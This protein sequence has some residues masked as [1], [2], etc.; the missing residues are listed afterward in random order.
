L[1]AELKRARKLKTAEEAKNKNSTGVD[2][3]TL[4]EKEE[5]NQDDDDGKEKSG[6]KEPKEKTD[7]EKE[8]GD[9][10]PICLEILPKDDTHFNRFTCCGNGIHIH[11][12]KDMMSM[13]M[14]GTCP[15]CRAKTPSCA[16][17]HIKYLRPW[18]KKKTAWAQNMMGQM[19]VQGTGV[20]QSYELAKVLYELAAQQGNVLAMGNLGV[21]YYK[22]LGVEQSY[23]RA[24]EYYAHAAHLGFAGAQKSLGVM[25]YTGNGVK[26]DLKKAREWWNKAAS[27]GHEDAIKNLK[28]LN[29][30]EGRTTTASTSSSSSE[31]NTSNKSSIVYCSTCQTPQT[32]TFILK[33]C[34]CRAAQ[35]C[36][37]TC[38][39]KHR[40]KHAKE[41]RR[42]TA[43]RKSKKK[44]S[45]K[46]LTTQ[47]EGERKEDEKTKPKQEKEEE[48][49]EEEGDECPICLENLPKDTTKFNRWTCCGNGIHKHCFKD[50]KSMKMA[51]TCPLCRAKTPTSDEEHIKQ[52]RPWVKKKKAWALHMMGSMYRKGEGVKQSYEMAKR[53]FEQAAQQGDVTALYDLGF[54]YENGQGV[55]KS[56]EKAF[57]YYEQAADLGHVSAQFNLGGLYYHGKG[58]ERDIA[59]A[60]E[61]WTASAA[62]GFEKAIENLKI[63]EKEMK[64]N[65][66]KNATKN[67]K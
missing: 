57:E 6:T 56:N 43:E 61:W 48:E 46:L 41:C 33:K 16:E 36:D 9:E 39:Q 7:K 63:L 45:K 4:P 15:F 22:G 23:E 62:Q 24:V 53:L 25:Y 59:K 66:T 11:C 10:C 60:K 67:T 35:Y 55:E 12:G 47:E 37:K 42:L 64:K 49:E 8:E 30:E 19:Y 20:K 29:K 32:E 58:V 51:G 2:A 28:I 31:T 3:G 17:D 14:A 44:Q 40:M 18:V 54:M 27:Q 13:K 50:M 65:M 52:L 26:R 34:S 21:M 38:Q 5:V 1:I